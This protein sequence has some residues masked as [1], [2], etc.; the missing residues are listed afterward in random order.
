MSWFEAHKDGLK[1]IAEKLVSSPRG[2]GIVGG[3]LYQNVMD[4]NATKCV[5][6]LEKIPHSKFA[7]LKVS[8]N[9]PD[10]FQDL[11]H[12]WT[13]FAPSA[14]KSDPTKAGR[15]N[16]GEKI[17]LAFCR[18][19]E[20]RTTKGTVFFS[21]GRTV[22][23]RRRTDSGTIFF[24]EI[25]CTGERLNQFEN[26]IKKI[27]VKPGL[28]LIFNGESIPHRS[29]IHKFE[30]KLATEISN[31]NGDLRPSARNTVVEIYEVLPGEKATLYEL[32]IPVVETEDKWHYNVKQKVPL[33]VERD[34]VTPAYLRSLRTYVLNE[35]FDKINE[36]DIEE[37]WLNDASSDDRCAADAAKTFLEL[38]YGKKCVA[39]D[40]KN[41]EANAEAVAHGYTL[42]PSHGL[43]SGQRANLYNNNL[44]SS[45]SKTFPNA[46][47]GAYSED[48]AP[49]KII[50]KE[51]WTE[52]MNLIHEYTVG[53]GMRILKKEIQVIFVEAKPNNFLACY[54]RGL[55]VR[56]F[57]YNV[58]RLGKKWFDNGITE[59]VDSLIIHEFGHDTESNHLS[60]RYHSALCECGAALKKAVL[61]DPKWFKK[62]IKQ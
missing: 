34:N 57:D 18:S 13:L 3:E 7:T 53:L 9:D 8:D 37:N 36:N 32:G 40:P 4:T 61:E 39:F 26:Y 54:G 49:A 24:A 25:E 23:A 59:E 15:F 48:G 21:E 10:G 5:I 55:A 27:I 43:N 45:S 31:E 11:S 60:E 30:V 14:K 17:V 2:F 22:N 58:A 28:D 52:G 62:F 12:A 1:Q 46:G 38:K 41:Q 20:I 42:I 19:A 29:P 16:F 35:M 33:N 6:D 47:R 51:N 44:L 50:P 56:R